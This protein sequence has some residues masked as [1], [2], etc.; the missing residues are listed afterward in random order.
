MNGA[1]IL[2]EIQEGQVLDV[3][4][5][6]VSAAAAVGG[7]VTLGLAHPDPT[8]VA[9]T[10]IEGVDG[11]VA[12]TTPDDAYD[13]QIFDEA[14]TAMIA[15]ADPAAILIAFT[16]RNAAFG[17]ALATR[18][19]LGFASGIIGLRREDDSLLAIRPMYG[20]K[21]H[22]DLEFDPA[23]AAVLLVRGSV[24]AEASATTETCP[25]RLVPLSD[26]DTRISHREFAPDE[27]TDIDLTKEDVI[28]TIGRG[29]GSAEKIEVFE[30]L[31]ERFGAALGSTRPLVDAG[32]LPTARQIGLSGVTVKPALYVAFG[33]SGALQ[34]QMGMIGAAT[35]I[36]VNT[37]ADAPIFEIAD[38]GS[39]A[40]MFEVAKHLED[41][42]G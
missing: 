40:D 32:W 26:P 37:D 9:G 34:H 5:E 13:H 19:D 6:M 15:E 39:T 14:L 38:Y 35:I 42:A 28:F 12:V 29:V 24:W 30:R 27:E 3:T 20:G 11:I 36:A 31:A 1:L 22:A 18:L 33:V 7:P 23:A 4:A 16:T 25:I 10:K 17:A 41:L 2:A 8:S 21:V